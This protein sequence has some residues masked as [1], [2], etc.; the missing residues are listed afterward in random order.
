MVDLHVHVCLVSICEWNVAVCGCDCVG[1][2]WCD[3]VGESGKCVGMIAWVRKCVGGIAL[4]ECGCGSS[5][6]CG[7][8]WGCGGFYG[9]NY[10]GVNGDFYTCLMYA[11]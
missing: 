7:C 6:L 2:C 11:F 4:I 9:C 1:V 5:G 3:C 8:D 10:V